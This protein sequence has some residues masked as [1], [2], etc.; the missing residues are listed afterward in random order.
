MPGLAPAAVQVLAVH[1]GRLWVVC[2]RRVLVWDRA[3]GVVAEHTVDPGEPLV[4]VAVYQDRAYLLTE[5][6]LLRRPAW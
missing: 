1:R 4:D 6:R 3:V 5:T 2:P